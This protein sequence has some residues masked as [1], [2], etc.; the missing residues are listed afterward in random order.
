MR[1]DN[2][3]CGQKH[4]VKWS[5]DNTISGLPEIYRD[6][7]YLRDPHMEC[8]VHSPLAA[9]ITETVNQHRIQIIQVSLTRRRFG[10]SAY[11]H[12]VSCRRKVHGRIPQKSPLPL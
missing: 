5:P 8:T 1:R 9:V 3:I 6:E 7:L 4:R 10:R 11:V 12:D 2:V